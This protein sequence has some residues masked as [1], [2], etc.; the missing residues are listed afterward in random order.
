LR[1]GG[2][3]ENGERNVYRPGIGGVVGGGGVLAATGANVT[4]GIVFGI[5]SIVAGVV[6]MR[7]TR[8]PH[9]NEN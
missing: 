4:W 5:V 6:L 2:S 3:A 1:C 9:G 7:F 8:R